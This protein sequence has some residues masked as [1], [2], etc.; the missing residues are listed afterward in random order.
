MITTIVGI[1]WYQR[2]KNVYNRSRRP[3]IRDSLLFE[4]GSIFA[5]N[6]KLID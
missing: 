6:C 4:F 5:S 2:A 1:S 3:R